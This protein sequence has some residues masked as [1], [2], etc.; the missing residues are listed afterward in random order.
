MKSTRQTASVNAKGLSACSP[1]CIGGHARLVRLYLE[2]PENVAPKFPT[3][4]TE[5]TTNVVKEELTCP[6]I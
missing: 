3:A 6:N 5:M 1:A 4:K 2:L